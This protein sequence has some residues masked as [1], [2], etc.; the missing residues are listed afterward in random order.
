MASNP[1]EIMAAG[2]SL[3]P[4][5]ADQE[6]RRQMGVL[7]IQGA[8]L[9]NQAQ[10]QEIKTH[11][12][13]LQRQATFTDDMKAYLAHPNTTGLVTLLGAHPEFHDQIKEAHAALDEDEQ[14]TNTTQIGSAAALASR[15]DYAGA[16][17]VIQ[18]RLA[19][20]KAA[21]HDTSDDQAILDHLNDPDPAKQ[22]AALGMMTIALAASV[23]PDKAAAFLK[24]NGLSS[25]P[26]TLVQGAARF[27]GQNEQVASVAAKPDFIIRPADA[28]LLPMNDSARAALAGGAG[29][30][31]AAPAAGGGAAP[32]SGSVGRSA[33]ATAVASTL[34]SA[35]LPAP[36]VAGFMGNFHIEGGYSGA[37]GDG[38]SASGIGQWHADR[39]A[40]FE[41]V[42]GK[43]VTEATPAEQANFVAWE[44]QNPQAAGMTVAQRDAILAAKTPAQ[45]AALI[46]QHY[47]RSNGVAR[48]ERMA[49]ATAFAGGGAPA[50]APGQ[51]PVRPGDPPGTIY[52]RPKPTAH[53][54]TAAEA[55]AKGLD[56][57]KVYQEHPDGTVSSVGDAV[58]N[59]SIPGDPNKTGPEYF[60]SLPKGMQPTVR[61]I[62]EGRFP[63]TAK[64]TS[65]NVIR[66]FEAA[67]R[68]DPTVD[69]TTYQ[70]RVATQRD[71]ASGGK[72]GQAL[73]SARTI[74]NHLYHIA[75][76]SDK[77]GGVGWTP[78]N[79]ISNWTKSLTSNKELQDYMGTLTPLSM[80]LPKFLGGKP[81]TIHEI[82][83]TRNDFS[84]D[85]GPEAR[86]QQV[87]TTLDLMQ[88]RFDPLVQSYTQGMNKS[89][90][91]S[92]LI[93]TVAGDP[94]AAARLR[95]VQNWAA[96]GHLSEVREGGAA[97]ATPPGGKLIGHAPDGRPVYQLPNGH[98]VYGK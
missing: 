68:V 38:G 66:L 67:N 26:Y 85:R 46:D 14:R 5:Y 63:I 62:I 8:T 53:V 17:G 32:A 6:L 41:R 40:N 21:G 22:K 57:S 10:A 56:P 92:E 30:A 1:A 82:E 83:Q 28:D 33:A 73:T 23:G 36:V 91:I 25:E 81:P 48:R 37:H 55:T 12:L 58:A 9:Q 65:P 15:G 71:F 70:R 42:I 86:R 39:V 43:P 64:M 51:N 90:D 13:A 93:A 16:A 19:A 75:L 4:N 89:A 61:A 98:K 45:A 69:A 7:Q 59:D 76:A 54:L 20:D 44:M 31:S 95:A 3:V 49:A 96:G 52:G 34:S 24:A 97:P 60:A 74:I 50:A 35:G 79:H 87:A 47:E 11:A 72:S 77:I 84:P 18:R 78:I 2:Q 29:T 80:E 27:N 88:G 94:V